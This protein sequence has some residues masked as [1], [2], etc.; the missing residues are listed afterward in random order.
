MLDGSREVGGQYVGIGKS[1]QEQN[2]ACDEN[3]HRGGCLEN[4]I[5]GRLFVLKVRYMKR[6][7]ET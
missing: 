1:K 4:A 2:Q 3:L 5:A 6:I 7:G